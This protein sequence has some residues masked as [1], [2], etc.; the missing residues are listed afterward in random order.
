MDFFFSCPVRFL[1]WLQNEFSGS[2]RAACR[3]KLF[4][5]VRFGLTSNGISGFGSGTTRYL[6]KKTGHFLINIKLHKLIAINL[7]EVTEI[8][9]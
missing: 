7:K 1:A 3:R 5:P 4:C 6:V 2:R 9:K 8:E